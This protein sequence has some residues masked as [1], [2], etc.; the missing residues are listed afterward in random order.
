M[1]S[2]IMDVI[3]ARGTPV[4]S[5]YSHQISSL[6]KLFSSQEL[7][8]DL[9]S[10]QPDIMPNSEQQKSFLLSAISPLAR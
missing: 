4:P 6:A 3:R 7:V 10:K 5:S 2:K 1:M 9:D 8:L